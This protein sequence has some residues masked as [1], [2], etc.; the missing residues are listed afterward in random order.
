MLFPGSPRCLAV[1]VVKLCHYGCSSTT[2]A[3]APIANEKAD[4]YVVNRYETSDLLPGQKYTYRVIAHNALGTSP[5]SPIV[6]VTTLS[7]APGA[8]LPPTFSKIT[9]TSVFI[10]WSSPAR[11]NGKPVTR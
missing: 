7:S 3:P 8:P 5:P 6:E 9:P 1:K 11:H 4:K 10:K 2:G